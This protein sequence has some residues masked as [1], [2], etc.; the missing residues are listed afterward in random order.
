MLCPQSPIAACCHC[1][2][3]ACAA[4]AFAYKHIGTRQTMGWEWRCFVPGPSDLQLPDALSRGPAE[5]RTDEYLLLRSPAVGIKI[6]GGGGGG[7]EVKTR[8]DVKTRMA[9]KWTKVVQACGD[10]VEVAAVAAAEGYGLWMQPEPE[11]VA[12]G[13]VE[14]SASEQ[15]QA[16]W[17]SVSKQRHQAYTETWPVRLVVE[18]TDLRLQLREGAAKGAV[19]I[20][21]PLFYRSFAVEQ[22]RAAELYAGVS[23]WLGLSFEDTGAEKSQWLGEVVSKLGGAGVVVGGFPTLLHSLDGTFRAMKEQRRP[24]PEFELG[25][26]PQ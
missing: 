21:A 13:A 25:V 9:E 2:L 18:Q 11:V 15:A 23:H 19:P 10:D 3:A 14:L 1:L 22:G 20:G 26:A 4:L 6:R 16:L 12:P 5:E 8:T 17:V 24:D 7:V